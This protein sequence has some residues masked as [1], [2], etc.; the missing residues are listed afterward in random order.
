MLHSNNIDV[1]LV[2]ADFLAPSYHYIK[3]IEGMTWN[4]FILGQTEEIA[5]S[6]TL[7]GLKVICTAPN[8]SRMLRQ[9]H[10]EQLW[11]T[12]ISDQI[13]WFLNRMEKQKR[14]VIF[15]N[16]GGLF[17]ST[18]VHCF[19]SEFVI[20]LLRPD[21]NDVRSTVNYLKT[22]KKPFYLVWNSVIKWEEVSN[23]VDRWTQKYF[24]TLE[25]YRGVL[26]KIPFDEESAYLKWIKGEN[27]PTG[28][29]YHSAIVEVSDQLLELLNS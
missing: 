9:I 11:S 1:M 19:F 20:C 25:N 12:T 16:Q 21:H 15:D 24:A 26:G 22:L 28:T 14:V 6:F 10:N 23:V 2:E 17:Y 13:S 3:K 8:D 18:L 5:P 29:G 27:F 7:E 4:E